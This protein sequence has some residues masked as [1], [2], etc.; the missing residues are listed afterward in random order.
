MSIKIASE[1]NKD[2]IYN[3]IFKDPETQEELRLFG[4]DPVYTELGA[5]VLIVT[6]KDGTRK[7]K[8]SIRTEEI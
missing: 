4:K 5:T 1:L 3:L 2:F 8:H 6:S 7:W